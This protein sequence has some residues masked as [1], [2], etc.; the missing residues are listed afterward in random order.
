MPHMCVAHCIDKGRGR[1]ER[2]VAWAYGLKGNYMTGDGEM[3]LRLRGRVT[4][5]AFVWKSHHKAMG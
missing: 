3:S 2:R 1:A 4:E 5:R